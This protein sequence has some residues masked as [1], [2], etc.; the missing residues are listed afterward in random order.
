ME[1]RAIPLAKKYKDRKLGYLQ[2]NKKLE[3]I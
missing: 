3:S 1:P 2:G